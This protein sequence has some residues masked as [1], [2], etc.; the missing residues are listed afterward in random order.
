[1]A[2]LL[3][4][5]SSPRK[6]RSVSIRVARAFLS[7]Y[8]E[9]HPQDTVDRL[10]LWNEDLPP[11]DGDTID[12]KYAIM[13]GQ[14]HSAGQ[15]AAWSRV[16]DACK[17]FSSADRYLL[18]VPMW[19]FG[20]PYVL[21][22]YIDVITQPGLTFSFSPSEGYKGLATGSPAVVVYARGGAYTP[23]AGTASFD[24]QKPYVEAFLGFVGFTDV[25]SIVVEPTM[26]DPDKV[27]QIIADAEQRARKAAVEL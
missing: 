20:V 25:R 8:E 13:N 14:P 2:R 21:K 12:A 6:E 24:L 10:D 22:H 17:R 18:S 23:E 7:A 11:F 5:E 3:Y 9:A 4:I 26:Q 15:A 19:N 1:M 16:V 27:A